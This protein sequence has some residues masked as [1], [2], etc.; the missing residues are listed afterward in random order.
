VLLIL[1]I[2]PSFALASE[3]KP[4]CWPEGNVTAENFTAVQSNILD[5]ISK[6]ITVL[7]ELC[8]N[9][10]EASNATELQVSLSKYKLDKEDTGPDN[11]NSGYNLLDMFDLRNEGPDQVN[12]FKC[13][14]LTVARIDQVPNDPNNMPKTPN[15]TRID[16]FNHM[17]KGPDQMN[18]F[19]C[20]NFTV[21][22]NTAG[23]GNNKQKN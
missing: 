15:M 18:E 19:K 20:D 11:M 9:V 3:N 14:N 13:D 22:K 2:A 17:N 7:N 23:I 5:S 12:G 6:Q 10:S 8:A 21:P 4:V 16:K 1:C